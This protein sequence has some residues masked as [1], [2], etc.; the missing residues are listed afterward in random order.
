MPRS[1]IKKHDRDDRTHDIFDR[2][3]EDARIDEWEADFDATQEPMDGVE[4]ID[5]VEVYS[6]HA[7]CECEQDWTCGPCKAAGRFGGYTW[8]E[9]RYDGMGDW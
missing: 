7:G 1:P 6:D 5:G 4:I 3:W 8:I 9:T 2:K